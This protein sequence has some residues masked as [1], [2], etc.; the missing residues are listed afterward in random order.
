MASYR[1][2]QHFLALE[3]DFAATS[4]YIGFSTQNY[5]AFSIEFAKL[6]LAVGSEI[7]VLNGIICGIL[8]KKAKRCNIDD[9]RVC[10]T[11]HTS[12]TSEKVLLRRYSLTFEPWKDWVLGKNP[13][14]WRSYNDVKHHRDLHF[15][16][17]NLENCANAIAGLFV[18]VLYCHKAEKS[19]DSLEPYPVLLGRDK[20][21][22]HFLL[23]EGYEVAPFT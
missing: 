9:Y 4:R 12:I 20:E 7:D 23:E 16:E 14:W 17:A 22:G 10:L 1:Y 19:T 15:A 5:K 6:L 21:L 8:D 18:I 11:A 13:S 2:W 3:A